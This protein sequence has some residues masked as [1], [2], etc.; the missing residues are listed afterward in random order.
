MEVELLEIRD[1]LAAHAPFDVLSPE[2]LEVLP[3]QLVVRYLR[4]GTPFPPTDVRDAA[5]YIVRS[6]AVELRDSDGTLSDKL[7]E[8]DLYAGLCEADSAV[9]GVTV[10]DSLLYLLDC[11]AL[12][13]LREASPGFDR[14]FAADR[15][16]R[17]QRASAPRAAAGLDVLSVKAADLLRREPVTL[18]GD[19][20]IRQ[21]AQLMS[22]QRVSSVLITEGE[23]LVGLIT[24]SDL[25]HRCLARGLGADSPA[26]SIMT[27]DPVTLDGG[28]VLAEALL[29]MT[30]LQ[31]H[32]LPVLMQGRLAGMLTLSDLA[33]HQ[34]SSPV[35]LATDIQRA[36]GVETLAGICRRLPELQSQLDLANTRPA[37]IGAAIASISDALTRRL[38]ELAESRLGSAPVPYVWAAGGSQGRQEQTVHSDQDHALIIADELNEPDREYFTELSRFVSDGLNACG[39]PYC[40]GNAMASNPQWRQPLQVWRDYFTGWIERPQPQ[41][42]M[43]ASIFFDLRAIHGEAALL[44]TLQEQV[45]ARTRANRIFIAHLTAAALQH[46]PPLGFFRNFVLIHDGEHDATLDLKRRGLLPIVDLARVYALSG[47][48]PAVNTRERLEAAM[49]AGA[50]GRELGG[51]LL[52]ALEFIAGLRI[53]HQA[54]CLREGRAPDNY[55]PPDTLSGL[56]RSHLKDAFRLIQSLQATLGN[57]YQAGRFG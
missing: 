30:R 35:L 41:A 48:I 19:M 54:G 56:E 26:R 7:G 32:H 24:D 2:L 50:L 31:V 25:R 3:R 40:P 21:A 16:E 5:L 39:F 36:D 37:H 8:G 51:S 52:D 43:H 9:T 18:D 17:L 28:E 42:L 55:L 14:Q 45:L 38:L 1:F 4:R 13:S 44:H 53:R 29:R 47:G 23:R 12:A 15:A 20:S 34:G 22:A 33:R 6:G 49:A 27:P 10:E 11:R 46:R 57:R